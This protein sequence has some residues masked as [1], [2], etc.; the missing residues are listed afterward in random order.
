[1]EV[2]DLPVNACPLSSR[3]FLFPPESFFLLFFL[4]L[5]RPYSTTHCLSS[6]FFYHFLSLPHCLPFSFLLFSSI[7]EFALRYSTTPRG[8]NTRYPRRPRRDVSSSSIK[9]LPLLYTFLFF[10]SCSLGSHRLQLYAREYGQFVNGHERSSPTELVQEFRRSSDI[11]LEFHIGSEPI[12]YPVKGSL[13]CYRGL[14]I[15]LIGYLIAEKIICYFFTV[16][17]RVAEPLLVQ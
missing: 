3:F 17:F 15:E 4:S 12:V 2:S 5:F 13:H 8:N 7:M 1:M 14:I 10:S 9:I 16:F 11:S 6:L